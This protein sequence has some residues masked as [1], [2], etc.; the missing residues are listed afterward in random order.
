MPAEA[1]VDGGWRAGGG[2]FIIT[3]GRMWR[4]RTLSTY[5]S[6]FKST[7]SLPKYFKSTSE[8]FEV[9]LKYDI[10]TYAIIAKI[11]QLTCFAGQILL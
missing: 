7:S 5:S 8:I 4:Y 11:A 2:M 1:M 3:Q 10:R 9:T 6:H